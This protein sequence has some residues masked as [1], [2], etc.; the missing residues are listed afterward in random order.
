MKKSYLLPMS[1]VLFAMGTSAHAEKSKVNI[2]QIHEVDMF[3]G[4][5]PARY[6]ALAYA[7]SWAGRGK[8]DLA[9]V[10]SLLKAGVDLNAKVVEKLDER[11]CRR[12]N[13]LFANIE[14]MR[15]ISREIRSQA[16]GVSASPSSHAEAWRPLSGQ[17]NHLRGIAK[18]LVEAGV[19]VNEKIEVTSCMDRE[20]YPGHTPLTLAL[21]KDLNDAQLVKLLLQGGA[22][23][24][25]PNEHGHFPL[26]IAIWNGN[27]EAIRVLLEGGARQELFEKNPQAQTV[28][29]EQVH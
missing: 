6:P 5:P 11:V 10:K 2:H 1:V 20:S 27:K 7:A 25:L 15:D 18:V 4:N 23:P 9:G 19:N 17:L 13:A 3:T 29:S 26:Q 22:N 24:N 21:D 14:R 12:Y 28:L 16:R 8:G